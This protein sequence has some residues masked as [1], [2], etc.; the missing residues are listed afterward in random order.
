MVAQGQTRFRDWVVTGCS[1]VSLQLLALDS[2]F[3]ATADTAVVSLLT[4]LS[5]RNYLYSLQSI[6]RLQLSHFTPQNKLITLIIFL[7]N[8]LSSDQAD[9]LKLITWDQRHGLLEEVTI[10]NYTLRI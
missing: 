8:C 4:L 5:R 9:T 2:D 10:V 7:N 3:A 6:E 1:S